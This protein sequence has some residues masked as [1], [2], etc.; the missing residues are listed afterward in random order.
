MACRRPAAGAAVDVDAGPMRTQGLGPD[1]EL[2][3]YYN[4]DVQPST[5]ADIDV[6]FA[7]GASAPIAGQ[8]NIIDV[9]P[10]DDGYSDFWR[11]TPKGC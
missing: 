6:L 11:M 4:V 3:S 7:A 1:G 10:G 8:L 9:L 2:V 5:P